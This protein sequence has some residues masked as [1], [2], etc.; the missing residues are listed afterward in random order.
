MLGIAALREGP[1]ADNDDLRSERSFRRAVP[2]CESGQPAFVL[3]DGESQVP[4][5]FYGPG[6]AT[7]EIGAGKAMGSGEFISGRANA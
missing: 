1:R 4:E 7:F 6:L 2:P 5:L 3:A